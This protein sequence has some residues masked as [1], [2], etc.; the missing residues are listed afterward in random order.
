VSP[1]LGLIVFPRAT[2]ADLVRAPVAGPAWVTF[3]RRPLLVAVVLGA[4]VT[5]AASGRAAPGLVITTTLSWS[6]VVLLQM[7][8]ALPLMA[9]GARRS[10]GLA[11]AV[12]LFFAGHALWSLMT[13]AAVLW[14]PSPMGRSFWPLAV[15]ALVPIA[16]TPRIVF[17]FF[18][19][20]LG[21]SR[22][23][24]LWMTAVQQAISWTLAVGMVWMTS[25]LTPRV[26][27]MLGRA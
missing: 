12:D 13:I 8:V 26:L 20:V 25:S 9:R 10:V 14:S 1:E 5:V 4:S 27:Q 19:I 18:E 23:E 6:Y 2:Y 17:T 22:R 16:L 24:A 11:R 15:F 7:A 3:V 21:M